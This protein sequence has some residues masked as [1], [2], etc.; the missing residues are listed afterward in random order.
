MLKVCDSCFSFV[1][2]RQHCGGAGGQPGPVGGDHWLPDSAPFLCARLPLLFPQT[3]CHPRRGAGNWVRV[4]LLKPS[5]PFRVGDFSCNY[6]NGRAERSFLF[7]LRGC[8]FR[9]NTSPQMGVVLV[10]SYVT[11]ALM[12][13]CARKAPLTCTRS[14]PRQIC[15]CGLVLY[16]SRNYSFYALDNQNLRQLWDWSK[17]KL[18]ILQGRIFFH[19][20]SKLCMSE[21]QKMEEVTGTKQRQVKND[22]ASKTNGDQASCK[23]PDSGHNCYLTCFYDNRPHRRKLI[24]FVLLLVIV[25]AVIS[26]PG[27]VNVFLQ[28]F[29]KIRLKKEQTTKRSTNNCVNSVCVH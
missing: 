20:N 23:N 16:F 25:M 27:V 9:S 8:S 18:T 15:L 6:T 5:Y 29:L 12:Q 3:P 2:C 4:A 21:I 14:V 11:N 26:C 19:Y 24:V 1:V 22:I 13:I 17:H 10:A 7:F 28:T